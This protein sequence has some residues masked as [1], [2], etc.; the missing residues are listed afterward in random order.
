MWEISI[1]AMSQIILAIILLLSK[2]KEI[3]DYILIIWLMILSLPFLHSILN[4]LEISTI[5][6]SKMLNQSF[7]LLHGPMLY[8]YLQELINS[9]QKKIKYWPHFIIFLIIYFIFLK[10]PAP[11]EPGGPI[12]QIEITNSNFSILKYFGVIN[13]AILCFMEYYLLNLSILIER[14]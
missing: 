6:L 3:S 5:F 10:T 1:I 14:K 9:N 7:T 4:E 13:I 8:L 2:K 12:D 11:L